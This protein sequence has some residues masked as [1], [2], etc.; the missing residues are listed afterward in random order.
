MEQLVPYPSRVLERARALIRVHNLVPEWRVE[1][2][3][4]GCAYSDEILYV[5]R[6]LDYLL[7]AGYVIRVGRFSSSRAMRAICRS[8]FV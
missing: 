5:A 1:R 7:Q 8:R 2:L 6:S 4:G 3:H